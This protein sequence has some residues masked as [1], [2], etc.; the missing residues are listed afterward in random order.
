MASKL[1]LG[2]VLVAGSL[3]LAACKGG[4]AGGGGDTITVGMFATTSAA[5]SAAFVNTWSVDGVQAGL[6]AIN[7]AGGV[8]GKKITLKVCDNAGDPN[9]DATCARRAVQEKW[10]AVLGGFDPYAPSQTLPV[11]EAGSVPYVGFLQGTPAEYQ[12]R[13]SF[14]VS[15]G[16]VGGYVGTFSQ[17]V[18]DGCKKPVFVG[19]NDA[20]SDVTYAQAKD[21]FGSAPGVTFNG[22]IKF[23]SGT[24]D[25]TPTVADALAQRP[26]CLAFG[27]GGNDA[28]KFFAAVRKAGSKATLYASPG[29]LQ[30]QVIAALGKTA[31]GIKGA[32]DTPMPNS[33]D[34]SMQK[35]LT[36]L[37]GYSAKAVPNEFSLIG[38]ASTLLLQQGLTGLGDVTAKGLLKKLGGM[39]GVK[40][41]NFPPLDFTK[42]RGSRQYPRMFNSSVWYGVVKNGQ[43]TSSGS[44]TPTDIG[45]YIK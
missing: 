18:H 39:S 26:D 19:A 30:P 14:P 4:A 24:T 12:S 37:K 44:Q 40:V 22:A 16:T 5:T 41:M 15:I 27:G 28:A 1:R 11:L 31:E 38:Y 10:V 9:R 13:V 42:T 21:V 2:A 7:A 43:W 25:V 6:K 34:P 23:T 45:Q 3:S 32:S 8:N 33:S 17:M 35:F 29:V 36:D 20:G